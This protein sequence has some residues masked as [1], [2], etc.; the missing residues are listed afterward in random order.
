V[1]SAVLI[2]LK[3]KLSQV[4]DEPGCYLMKNSKGN[5][6][7]VGKAVSL[8]NRVGQYLGSSSRLDF[9]TQHLVEDISDF[10][11]IITKTGVEAL[12]L[13]R[14]LIKHHKPKFNILLR[15]DKEY[16]Y[17]RIALNED[18]PR[19]EKVRRRK[20]D[21][22][23]YLGPFTSPGQLK[24]MMDATYRIFPLIRCS[25]HEFANT[26]RPCNY[27]HM[28]MCLAP[29]TKPVDKAQYKSMI[30]DA[31]DFLR[32][33]NKD[34]V[35]ALR[36]KMEKAADQENFE[37]AAVYRDQLT[38]FES[39]TEKQSVVVHEIE[40]AD[41]VGFAKNEI[42]VSF[43][44][45]QIRDGYLVSSDL[46]VLKSPVQNEQEAMTEFLIQY[47][48]G[49]SLPR[50]IALPFLLDDLDQIKIALLTSHPDHAGLTMRTPARGIWQNLMDMAEKNATHQLKDAAIE[51]ERRRTE[52][53][54]IREKLRL[55]KTP[56]RIE[57]I[58]ISNIQGTA[59]VAS[60]VC[61]IDGKPARDMYRH[62]TIKTVVGAPD[63]FSS[64]YEV[65]DRRLR[66][67]EEEHD[68]PDLLVIDGGRGQL[69]SAMAAMALHPT[70]QVEIVSLAKS[71]VE[72]NRGRS[73]FM[74]T[75]DVRRT[76]ERIFFPD[77]ESPISL[78]PGTPEYRL[79]TQI[80]DE[81]HRF[82][83]SHHRKKR[84]KI[85]I[86][87]DLDA[88]PGIGPK[89]RVKLLE[90]FGSLENLKKA[91][92]DELVNI[93]G[94]RE[95]SAIALHSFLQGEDFTQEKLP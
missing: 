80:R 61:F 78:A 23:V 67:A 70:V 2:R 85:S 55:T 66:R 89:L 41:I 26:K 59:I 29:C 73:E 39:I 5:I 15:D 58:D 32:G 31:V 62:Y 21:G 52:L 22:S 38:A 3:A 94:L 71:K 69:S 48:D 45:M 35:K 6:I 75:G 33:N 8:K 64:I 43:Y 50:V 65:V 25:K 37:L 83:I 81:A 57:C 9:K 60:N 63:D 87:S 79:F 30:E 76:F 93:K 92:L 28:K 44:I 34:L 13:E 90:T 12:L 1:E 47:Y 7:Y 16:P 10:E 86:G 91:S 88:I 72:K 17:L 36:S 40:S 68:L 19:I 11:I 46:Y 84:A 77:R 95:S 18:W 20:E 53:E 24:T 4:P 82:A 51:E 14:T 74:S 54:V 42:K 27:F 56:H 49:R